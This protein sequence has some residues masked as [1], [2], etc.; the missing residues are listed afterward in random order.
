MEVPGRSPARQAWRLRAALPGG[1]RALWLPE[2][3]SVEDWRLSSPPGH[4][5]A[6]AGIGR[7]RA[8][9]EAP[10]AALGRGALPRRP[11]DRLTLAEDA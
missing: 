9:I 1:P 3:L 8:R 10:I 5:D 2:A 11:F 4:A 7:N 6:C